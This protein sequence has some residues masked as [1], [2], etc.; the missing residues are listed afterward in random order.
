MGRGWQLTYNNAKNSPEIEIL[1]RSEI[2]SFGKKY[3]KYN[4][5][6]LEIDNG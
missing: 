3:V 2:I 6:N 1:S 4:Y 5:H